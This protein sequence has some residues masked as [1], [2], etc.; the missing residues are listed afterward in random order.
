MMIRTVVLLTGCI[1]LTLATFD[2]TDL[3]SSLIFSNTLLSKERL[4]WE[5][6]G[7]NVN[8]PNSATRKIYE[9]TGRYVAKNLVATRVQ[10]LKHNGEVI[11]A[12]PRYKDGCAITLAKTSI[13]QLKDESVVPIFQPYPNWNMQEEGNCDAIQS[14][15]D[16]FFDTK[17]HQLWV[18]DSGVTN[19][20]SQ[21]KC[22]NR[23]PP[24]IVVINTNTH[25]V[26]KVISLSG[27]VIPQSRLQHLVVETTKEGHKYVYVSD[28]DGYA[29]IVWDVKKSRGRRIV[30]PPEMYAERDGQTPDDLYMALVH[31]VRDASILYL[32]YFSSSRMF[33]I[34]TEF[35][36]RDS[37]G[38]TTEV[39]VKPAR[40]IILGVDGR[41]TIFFK[42]EGEGNVYQW[43]THTAFSLQNFV[44]VHKNKDRLLPT[45]VTPSG[46]PNLMVGINSNFQDYLCH[47]SGSVGPTMSVFL[48]NSANTLIL[49]E[50]I[51]IP[52]RP[53]WPIL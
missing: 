8:F 25:T 38:R 43:N 30:L 27:L 53:L 42:Y 50:K 45:H 21:T 41:S 44:L 3:E 26:T 7:V 28:T 11:V 6:V 23:C 34:H 10:W 19:S 29:I 5:W 37:G 2:E 31:N 1:S 16:I 46:F 22:Y 40:M 4:R 52:D 32:T 49:N 14:A 35:L 47:K 39:G 20:L 48:F 51:P 17:T 24:K 15:V 36:H 9:T 13:K 33:S 18:L 12:I